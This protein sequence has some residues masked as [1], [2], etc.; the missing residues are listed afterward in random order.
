MTRV[1]MKMASELEVDIPLIEDVVDIVVLGREDSY[2]IRRCG[3]VRRE[4]VQIVV[5]TRT[6]GV[7]ILI[8]RVR[9]C[10]EYQQQ[11]VVEAR[12]EIQ[13]DLLGER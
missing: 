6:R 1:R 5:M 8:G 3:V 12:R 2:G 9:H 4:R 13:G 10:L 11:G 7:Q